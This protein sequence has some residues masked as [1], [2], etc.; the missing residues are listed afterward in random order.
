MEQEGTEL[1]FWDHLDVL[2][3]SIIRILVVTITCGIVAFCFKET[4]FNIVLAPKESDFITYKL[5]GT[6]P[7]HIQ[8]IN[9]GL[10]EQFIIHMKTAFAFGFLCASPYV[11][12]VLYKFISP[13]LYEN[14]RRYSVRIVSSAYIM[15]MVGVLVNYFLIYPLTVR[16]LGTYQV[17]AQVQTMLSLQSYID[18]MLFMSLVFAIIFEI[19][20]ISWVLAILGLLRAEWMASYRK[21][22]F[23]AIVIIAAIIT[24]TSDVFTLTIVSLP[25]WLLYEASILI[26]KNAQKKKKVEDDDEDENKPTDEACPQPSMAEETAQEPY[27]SDELTDEE[28][29]QMN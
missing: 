2:R 17:S 15:G 7:F 20:V 25:I 22:A 13:A 29:R 26:V 3:G 14:E 5:L 10:T 1:T 6:E 9:V 16:F 24:P 21:H 12:Y 8:L 4:L 18:T 23:V 27:G 11:L 28:V 19:P